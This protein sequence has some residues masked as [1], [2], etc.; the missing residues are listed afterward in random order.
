[1]A[2]N[3]YDV[4]IIGSGPAGSSC[5][6]YTA[7]ARL[8]TAVLDRS[9]SS[10]ALAITSKIA[11]Y[12]GVRGEVLGADLA[13]NMRAQASDFGAEFIK[14]SAVGVDFE[15]DPKQ[16]FTSDGVYYAQAIVIAT[17]AMGRKERVLGEEEFLGKGVSY[18]ATCD[19][20]FFSD[21][22]VAVVGDTDIAVE[23]S[24]FLTRFASRVHL[25]A[26]RNELKAWRELVDSVIEHER[27]KIYYNIR[28]REITGNSVVNGVTMFNSD[29]AM[30]NIPVDGV[31]VLLTGASPTT[32]FLGNAL[33]LTGE[34]C[35]P[36]DA[37]RMTPIPG[38]Y[39]IGDVTC[40]H[41]KQAVIAA[42]DGVTAALSIDK[43]LNRRDKI[44]VD[45]K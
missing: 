14:T 2:E 25:L 29:G 41:M 24:L 17:G 10:G 22:E 31:F 45:Y 13:E 16:V 11:N 23:E 6:I 34:G 37:E 28:L 42:A 26:P 32:D 44:K 12:P 19:G 27:I 43:Y 30:E 21:Q 36:I 35:I 4:I 1:M 40:R 9:G 7:R 38:V 5:A 39:A 15:S 8:K 3:T 18:C 20:A 33:P